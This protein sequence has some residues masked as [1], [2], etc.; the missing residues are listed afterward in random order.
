MPPVPDR[1]VTEDGT[2]VFTGQDIKD[3]QNVWQSMGGQEL[4][5]IWG[6][7]AY[8]APDW[9][10]DWL[11]RES[12]FLLNRWSN[13]EFGAD[14]EDLDNEQQAQLQARLKK[15]I[16]TNTYNP[17]TNEIVISLD[18]ADAFRYLSD[19]YEGLFMDDPN[20]A[21]LRD[22]YAIPANTIRDTER[23]R[24]MNTFFFWSTWSTGTNRPDSDITYTN[25]WPNEKLI[26][27]R[28]TG[29]M[30]VWSVVSFVM[31][32]AGVGALSLVFCCSEEKRTTY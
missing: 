13:G 12:L 10:A 30:V 23:M 26:D 24:H 1:V 7:G 16:R 25:N 27:N 28:P 17:E 20:F 31:L 2:E 11:H 19:Y 15:E 9:N 6:H 3:G 32:L 4:G 18:R 5:S 21:Q 29:E 14:F 22:D 8:V